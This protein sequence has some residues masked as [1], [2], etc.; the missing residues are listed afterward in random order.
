MIC[1]LGQAKK[2][3]RNEEYEESNKMKEGVI[4]NIFCIVPCRIRSSNTT[5]GEVKRG[6]VS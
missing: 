6:A 4:A 3:Y 1:S 5:L 2:S